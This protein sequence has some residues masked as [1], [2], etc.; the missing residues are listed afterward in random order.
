MN[1]QRLRIIFSLVMGLLILLCIWTYWNLSNYIETVGTVRQVNFTIQTTTQVL[2]TIKDAETGHRGYLLTQDESYLEPFYHADV[3]INTELVKLDSVS[4][5]VPEIRDD[6]DHL[7]SLVHAQLNTIDKILEANNWK[8]SPL[9]AGEIL[10]LQQGK[11]NM[12]EIR[13]VSDR[14]IQ[15]ARKLFLVAIEDEGG[16]KTVTPINLLVIALIAFGGILLLFTRAVMLLDERDKKSKILEMAVQNLEMETQKRVHTGNLL[17]NVLDN[18]RDGIM[19]FTAVRDNENLVTDFDFILANEASAK[20]TH[21]S[22]DQLIKMRLSDIFSENQSQFLSE[23]TRV[24]ETGVDFR[25]EAEVHLNGQMTWFKILAVKFNDGMLV[26]LSDISSE[27]ETEH[28]LRNYTQELKRSNEDLEQFAYVAS[29]DLQEPLRK[30]RSFGDRL[31]TKYHDKLDDT[32]KDYIERMQVASGRMQNLIEDLLA[33]SRI[34]RSSELPGKVDLKKV[35]GEICDDLSDQ[36][37]RENAT[38]EFA[39]IP[40]VLGVKAQIQRLFQNLISNAIKFRKE[41][42]NPHITITGEKL[43]ALEVTSQFAFTPR[44]KNYV[45]ITV[46]DNG[47][48]FDEKYAE[49]IF[50]VFQRLHGKN[51]FEGTGIGLAICKKIVTHHGGLITA[52]SNEGI[53][54]EFIVILPA[55]N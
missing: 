50:N 28:Q 6:V 22:Q 21:Q 55:S 35:F 11:K 43:T 42:E 25:R 15:A 31:I 48:G 16:F 49:Q 51:E 54:S 9:E 5:Y 1:L 8:N 38:F 27:K 33:F 53:G 37:S 3:S 18:S 32:G 29:H 23:Y 12:D 20:M 47:I 36:I 17:R 30:I 4:E 41:N 46:S 2:S 13:L 52:R 7:D 10:L 24:V 39:K 45:K 14:I 40:A 19:A 26:T 44:Y 34:T